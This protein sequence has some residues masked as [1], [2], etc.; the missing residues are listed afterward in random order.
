M[1]AADPSRAT[2]AAGACSLEPLHRLSLAS[3]PFERPALR[4]MRV[5]KSM[6]LDT[7]VEIFSSSHTGSGQSSIKNIAK[8]L[9]LP[10]GGD[11]SLLRLLESQPS[12]DEYSLRIVLRNSEF[13]ETAP[14]ARPAWQS[15]LIDVLLKDFVRPLERHVF[16]AEQAALPYGAFLQRLRADDTATQRFDAL[17]C[18]LDSDSQSVLCFLEDYADTAL[19]LFYYR[20]CLEEM[21][22]AIVDMLRSIRDLR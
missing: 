1:Q 19:S 13:A 7:V 9:A 20:R 16:D 6:C 14:A 11:L 15:D 5:V 10:P 18:R 8:T 3:L 2:D 21:M 12:F 4:K 22:P 17:A